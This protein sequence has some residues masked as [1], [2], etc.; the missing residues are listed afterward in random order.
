MGY[1]YD[2]WSA[3]HYG[4]FAFSAKK[5]EPTI[6]I[7]KTG[8]RVKAK[9]GL[10]VL[11]KLDIAKVRAMYNCNPIPSFEARKGRPLLYSISGSRKPWACFVF[12]FSSR[13]F[14]VIV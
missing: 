12:S 6:R 8:R 14:L 10:R 1:A 11:S 3:M 2:Y 13:H 5:G 7:K 9:I 4:P